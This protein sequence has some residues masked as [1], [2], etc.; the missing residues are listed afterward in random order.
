MQPLTQAT[1]TRTPQG[2]TATFTPTADITVTGYV[3][4][5]I[6][7]MLVPIS[8]ATVQAGLNIGR[9]VSTTTA[10]DGSYSLFLPG[11]YVIGYGAHFTVSAPGYQTYTAFYSEASLRANPVIY[12]VL[13]PTG[14]GTPP[15]PTPTGPT[16]TPTRTPTRTI[17]PT[18]TRTLTGPTLTPTRTNT[19][20]ITNTPTTGTCS[21]VTST[22]TAPFTWD[23]AGTFCWQST[24][25]G[26]YMNSWNTTS[27]NINGVN[28]TN[29]YIPAG[30]YPAKVN[31]FWYVGYSSSVAWGHFEAK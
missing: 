12:F 21:P 14:T 24:N 9:V 23:G 17:T 27:V 29:V 20:V 4:N 19:P 8:G 22:I 13:V 25:L 28:I 3:H 1:P 5:A 15:T 7:D 18:I 16:L 6:L 26:A 10:S 11:T 30:S 2:P 31:G